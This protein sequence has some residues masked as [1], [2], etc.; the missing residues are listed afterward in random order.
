MLNLISSKIVNILCHNDRLPKI[1]VYIYGCEL[2][3]YTALSTMWLLLWGALWGQPIFTLIIVSAFYVNQTIGGGFH[4]STHM[5]CM[6]TMLVGLSIALFINTYIPVPAYTFI[7]ILSASILLW[8][9]VALHRQ[10]QYLREK[11]SFF[12]TYS[13]FITIGETV[14]FLIV[15]D[16]IPVGN[17]LALGLLVSGISRLAGVI[18]Q[19][20]GN[21]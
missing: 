10:K 7:A 19:Q 6:L 12:A 21:T 11:A 18:T 2:I 13:R 9:P 1:H 17:A 20:V 15:K 14:L 4:A 16:T 8:H 3:I 5:R